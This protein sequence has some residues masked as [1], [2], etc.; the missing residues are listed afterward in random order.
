MTLG[1][2]GAPLRYTRV[3]QDPGWGER[4][5]SGKPNRPPLSQKKPGSNALCTQLRGGR[6]L[7]SR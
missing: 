6:D 1:L 3:V 7:T 5:L 2:A 4:G